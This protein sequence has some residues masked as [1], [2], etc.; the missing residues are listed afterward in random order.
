[1]N[2]ILQPSYM[3]EKHGNLGHLIDTF[4]SQ[5]QWAEAFI[6]AVEPFSADAVF[7]VSGLQITSQREQGNTQVHLMHFSLFSPPPLSI[8]RT[9]SGVFSAE[10]QG[11][12]RLSSSIRSEPTFA[13]LSNWVA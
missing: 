13:E 12:R 10:W 9:S 8:T 3:A 1:M 11:T 4:K 7:D 5:Q 6:R 2:G